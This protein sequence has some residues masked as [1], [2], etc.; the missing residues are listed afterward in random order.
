MPASDAAARQHML[1]A[2][3]RASDDLGQA[4]ASLGAAYEQLDERQADRL[5][6]EL[7]RP[8]QSAYGRAQRTHAGFAARY[9][10]GERSFTMASPGVPSTGVR[11][12]IEN[13]MEAV[14]RAEH[15]LVEIQE[16]PMAIEVGDVEFRAGL[17]E[18]RRLI[19]D[20]SRHARAFVSTFGR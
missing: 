8:V 19:D 17:S 6:E 5:E 12:F 11:G 20:F 2:L 9:G 3:A 18:T 10:L 14:G 16:S 7:F 13:A 1:D 4:L 15:Q